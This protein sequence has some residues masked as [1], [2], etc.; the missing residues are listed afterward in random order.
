MGSYI[1]PVKTAVTKIISDVNA[2]ATG[3]SRSIKFGL[4]AYKDHPPQDLTY[5]TKILDLSEE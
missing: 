4:V 1:G 5:L 2:L 3:D